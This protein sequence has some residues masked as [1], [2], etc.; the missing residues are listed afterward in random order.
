LSLLR[1]KAAQTDR[2]RY[3]TVTRAAPRQKPC[4][5]VGISTQSCGDEAEHDEGAGGDSEYEDHVSVIF[6]GHC[7]S[8][9]CVSKC[10]LAVE[11]S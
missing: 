10:L 5:Q 11:V 2:R 3:A 4:I 8:P 1:D 9:V 6:L 7:F